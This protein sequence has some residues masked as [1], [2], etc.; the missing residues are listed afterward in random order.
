MRGVSKKRL[1]P[2]P[3]NYGQKE[4]DGCLRESAIPRHWQATCL[5]LITVRSQ[6]MCRTCFV[7]CSVFST[8]STYPH[9]DVG[10]RKCS[11]DFVPNMS[12]V[13]LCLLYQHQHVRRQVRCCRTHLN[14]AQLFFLRYLFKLGTL[15]GPPLYGPLLPSG[16]Q[17]AHEVHE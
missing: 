15:N 14:F 6:N 4:S 16:T 10:S 5:T 13:L 17:I 12:W 7:L 8:K 1:I 11:P 2:M 9:I 3:A